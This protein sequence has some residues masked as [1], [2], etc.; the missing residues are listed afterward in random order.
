MAERIQKKLQDHDFSATTDDL[1]VTI[2][3]GITVLS[4]TDTCFDEAL[5]KAKNKGR[6]QV[7]YL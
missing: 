4:G 3:I 5:Y 2:S 1:K 6:N 7:V